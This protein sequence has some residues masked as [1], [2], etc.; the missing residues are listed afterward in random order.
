MPRISIKFQLTATTFT[1]SATKIPQNQKKMRN[2]IFCFFMEIF[3]L[4]IVFFGEWKCDFMNNWHW[5]VCWMFGRHWKFWNISKN[6]QVFSPA[7]PPPSD[8]AV[9]TLHPG[10]FF[11]EWTVGGRLRKNSL[12]NYNSIDSVLFSFHKPICPYGPKGWP[13]LIPARYQ[14]PACSLSNGPPESPCWLK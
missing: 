8:D 7:D 14:R 1:C 12:N 9:L 5:R 10:L 4:F 13:W 6:L 3:F 2:G 11:D